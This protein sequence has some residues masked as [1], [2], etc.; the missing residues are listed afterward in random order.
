MW[1]L[2]VF[3]SSASVTPGNNFLN[4][5]H[6]HWKWDT[7]ETEWFVH[8]GV[9]ET[10]QGCQQMCRHVDMTLL[11]MHKGF[12]HPKCRSRWQW[13]HL[14]MSLMSCLHILGVGIKGSMHETEG[15]RLWFWVLSLVPLLG[16]VPQLVHLGSN[17]PTNL[18]IS[19][20]LEEWNYNQIGKCSLFVNLYVLKVILGTL[21]WCDLVVCK[22]VR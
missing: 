13:H 9:R 18:A 4:I 2:L 6:S 10:G 15:L 5:S 21:S 17:K 7:E 11:C 22:L 1:F 3:M 20:P 12:S 14:M 16:L 8:G 19:V